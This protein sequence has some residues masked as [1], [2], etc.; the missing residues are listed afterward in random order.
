MPFAP[1]TVG[2]GGGPQPSVL[3]KWGGGIVQ[4]GNYTSL[5]L[6]GQDYEVRLPGTPG[7]QMNVP[8]IYHN[9]SPKHRSVL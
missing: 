8:A 2:A 3:C 4:V 1:W 7:I 5:Y 6:N 9:A